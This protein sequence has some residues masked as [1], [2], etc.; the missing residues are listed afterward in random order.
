MIAWQGKKGNGRIPHLSFVKRKPEPL[1]TECKVVC[2]GR[3]GMCVYIE[4]QRV[5]L[6]CRG[7]N[8]A[9]STKQLLL[10]PFGFWIKWEQKS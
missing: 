9:V 4:I 5:K 8:G 2:E 10:V 1:G 3:F 6:Q 7:K